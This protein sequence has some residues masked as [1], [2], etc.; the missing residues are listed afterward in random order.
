MKKLGTVLLLMS[1]VLVGSWIWMVVSSAEP[2]LDQVQQKTL[3][4]Q[5]NDQGEV[6]VEVTPVVL[7]P[8]KEARFEVSLNTH[9]IELDYDLL[10]VSSISDDKGNKLSPLSWSGGSGGHHLTGELVFPSLSGKAKSVQL[11][12]ADISGFNRSFIWNL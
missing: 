8:G 2:A 4:R 1:V 11:V 7:K 5:S 6:I 12:I 9:T 3:I 10:K